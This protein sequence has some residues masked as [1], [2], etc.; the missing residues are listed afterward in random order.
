MSLPPGPRGPAALTTMH[1]LAR[2]YRFL[3]DCHARFGET[4]SVRLLGLPPMVF[5]ANP[6]VV[7]EV[8]ASDGTDMV[9]GEFN[10]TL[11]PLLGDRS[12]LMV[13]GKQ[14]L[15][16]RKLLLPPFHGER[17]HAYGAAMAEITERAVAALPIG[18]PFAL[19][20]V[21]QDITLQVIVRTIFGFA[22]GPRFD[23]MVKRT[24]RILELGAWPP[25]LMPWMQF[26]AGGHSPYGRFKEAVRAGDERLFEEIRT[27]RA[28]G[29][30][31]TD[32]L[33]VLLDAKDEQGEPFS[34][35]ELRDELVT[36]LVA[37]HETTAT[38]LTWAFRWLL[39]QPG[40]Y[41][42]L[43]A[44]VDGLGSD[45]TP[46]A[47][48]AEPLGDATCREA[49]RLVPVI[50]LVGRL[51]K[52]P[53]TLGGYDLPVGTVVACSIY[54][55]HRRAAVYPNPTDFDPTRF[56][57][58]KLSPAEFFPFGGGLRR[59][60]GMAF[61]LYEMKIVL[62]RF[63]ALVDLR[64]A[65]PGREIRMVRRSITITPEHG[66]RVTARRRMRGV[67][68]PRK[69]AGDEPRAISAA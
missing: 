46:E 56:L 66:L 25:L 61:A 28:S 47:I 21:M 12:V 1:W 64:L 59:C 7:R 19:H 62:A 43:R 50:P 6:E 40:T 30:R 31:G 55:A 8:F 24:Q 17:M 38:A 9:A 13:D 52:Q 20:E 35:Q 39:D 63:L 48:A 32:I 67:A 44:A 49:L 36:L 22:E 57:G 16:K 53:M 37:G 33:S 10:R 45:P 29:E 2:P 11:A 27:R 51:T 4:F 65:H 18:Q 34:D 58:K 15:R 41:A 54:L 14:H 69:A 68:S 5:F 3:D 26:E 42:D 60:V 23:D